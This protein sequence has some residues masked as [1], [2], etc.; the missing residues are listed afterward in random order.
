MIDKI[1]SKGKINSG[2]LTGWY[3]WIVDDS[4]ST[5]GYLVIQSPNIDFKGKGFDN[6][7]A[8]IDEVEQFFNHNKWEIEWL[9]N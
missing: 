5:G 4:E 6:W 9:N 7:F 3:I 2:E 8:S 1:N